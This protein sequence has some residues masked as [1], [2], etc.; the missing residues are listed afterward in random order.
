M[1]REG[2]EYVIN[3]RKWWIFRRRRSALPDL[4]RDGQDR[5][6]SATKHSQQSMILVPSD[7]P[8]IKVMRPLSVFGYDDAPHGH[9]EIDVQ[10]RARAGGQHAARRRARLR[11]RT[12]ASRPRP[13]SSLHAFDRAGRARARADV[14]ATRPTRVA[15]GRPVA[16]QT[17]WQERIAEARC[18]HRPGAPVDAEGGL[19][20]GHGR[21]QGGEGR[22]RDDQGRRAQ[23]R[24]HGASTGRSRRT[25]AAACATTFR[26][27]YAYAH[28]AHLAA[29]RWTR[30]G[31][32]Q[33]DRKVRDG[34][35]RTAAPQT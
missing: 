12:G 22:D 15:F 7:T 1:Q 25:A 20:D 30:R 18:M 28:C 5:S 3:G 23:R 16:R 26:S 2:D 29:G 11:D 31:P 34:K 8:G 13:H 32:S 17:V 19:D 24:L 4:H 27:A 14:H 6:R 33:R 21:Q 9:M 35:A 10:E